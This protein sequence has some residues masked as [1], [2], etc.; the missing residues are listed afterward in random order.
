MWERTRLG[1]L[2]SMLARKCSKRDPTEDYSLSDDRRR[3][4]LRGKFERS[5][6]SEMMWPNVA[7]VPP[8][9]LRNTLGLVLKK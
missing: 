3:V 2:I 7:T 6:A 4:R 1:S 8:V 5:E 9:L